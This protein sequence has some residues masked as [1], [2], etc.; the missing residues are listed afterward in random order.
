MTLPFSEYA[1]NVRGQGHE[2]E[3]VLLEESLTLLSAAMREYAAC[4]GELQR[5]VFELGKLQD[6][7]GFSNWKEIVHFQRER[8]GECRQLCLSI[9]GWR[10]QSLDESADPVDRSAW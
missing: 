2:S 6:V 1:A 7:K 8:A 4:G 3:Q 5:P 10:R 9:V